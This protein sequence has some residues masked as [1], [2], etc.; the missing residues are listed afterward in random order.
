MMRAG[1]RPV[2]MAACALM[3]AASALGLAGGAAINA[4][5]AA[6]P[7]ALTSPDFLTVSEDGTAAI[8]LTLTQAPTAP[9]TLQATS[10]NSGKIT[11]SEAQ[12]I[13]PG[14]FVPGLTLTFTLTGVNDGIADGDRSAGITFVVTS[15]DTTYGRFVPAP[16]AV[17]ILDAGAPPEEA[18]GDGSMAKMLAIEAFTGAS[19]G[20]LTARLM[21]L[22][23]AGP[24]STSLAR[25]GAAASSFSLAAK[26]GAANAAAYATAGSGYAL[27]LW[28]EAAYAGTR[29]DMAGDR[30]SGDH[31]IARAGA[32]VMLF[33]G[34]ITGLMA[35][36]DWTS[37]RGPR[38][39][40]EVK[41]SEGRVG[42][43]LSAELGQGIV[44]DARA[45]WGWGKAEARQEVSGATYEGSFHTESLILE[46]GLSGEFEAA[47]L[48][49]RPELGIMYAGA[50]QDDFSIANGLDELSVDGQTVERGEAS[51]GLV[52]ARPV[53][54][55][56][57]T[58]T[59]YAGAHLLI[60]VLKHDDN[61]SSR[62]QAGFTLEKGAA[63]LGLHLGYD[64]LGTEARTVTAMLS[65]TATF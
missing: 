40:D 25:R 22:S 14:D 1:L 60:D 7:P 8:T 31:L 51:L 61:L 28:S 19:E 39:G 29:F 59:P 45:L 5:R 17:R 52:I 37:T 42:P 47:S 15:A 43:Y 21:A 36:G 6:L 56:S 38:D 27:T 4:A 9:V 64:G 65:F 50:S 34:L 55:G 12:T 44:F 35:E 33:P 20:Y 57:F 23:G 2:R 53:D 46:A 41:G 48:L 62:L 63:S 16:V 24:R 3:V 54:L 30:V 58:L 10:S 32:D 49:I 11:V 18:E 13:A 26:D